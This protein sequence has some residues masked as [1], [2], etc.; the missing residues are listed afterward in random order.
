MC[1]TNFLD[2]NLFDATDWMRLDCRSDHPHRLATIIE[3]ELAGFRV[4]AISRQSTPSTYRRL[5]SNPQ[6]DYRRTD[7]RSTDTS[8]V[9]LPKSHPVVL[10]EAWACFSFFTPVQRMSW[11]RLCPGP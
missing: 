1:R 2:V 4:V 8:D 3:L 10:R 9:I 11:S 5:R 6:G 7:V